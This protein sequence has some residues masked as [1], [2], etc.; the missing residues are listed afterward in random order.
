MT[1]NQG[2]SNLLFLR[3]PLSLRKEITHLYHY[4]WVATRCIIGMECCQNTFQQKGK[5]RHSRVMWHETQQARARSHRSLY[6]PKRQS[7][8]VRVTN[9]L[10]SS[11]ACAVVFL[12]VLSLF[13]DYGYILLFVVFFFLYKCKLLV[14][15]CPFI[16]ENKRQ[17]RHQLDEEVTGNGRIRFIDQTRL[18]ETRSATLGHTTTIVADIF[19]NHPAD[20][21]SITMSCSEVDMFTGFQLER[22]FG[23]EKLFES[24]NSPCTTIYRLVSRRRE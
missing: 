1:N 20:F 3:L 17:L 11:A 19:N 9:R 4:F 15:N 10:L 13:Y 14:F 22:H 6:S 8:K 24:I 18:P 12:L 23:A 5:I 2:V 21:D 16:G 7:R